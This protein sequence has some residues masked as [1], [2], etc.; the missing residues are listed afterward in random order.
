MFV[1]TVRPALAEPA[2]S[3]IPCFVVVA[4]LT[5][6]DQLIVEGLYRHGSARLTWSLLMLTERGERKPSAAAAP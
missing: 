3:W 4:A 1:G 5:G 2:F 6:D